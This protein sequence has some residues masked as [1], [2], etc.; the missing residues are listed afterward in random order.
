MVVLTHY[1][2][3]GHFYGAILKFYHKTDLRVFTVLEFFEARYHSRAWTLRTFF[4]I[5]FLRLTQ[6]EFARNRQ[7]VFLHL[8]PLSE[9]HR[10]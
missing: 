8:D 2:P 6:S 1:Q 5:K 7:L 10:Y 9:N 3:T 4:L